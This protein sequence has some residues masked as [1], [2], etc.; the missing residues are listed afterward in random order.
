MKEKKVHILQED[1]EKKSLALIKQ[2]GRSIES[3][4]VKE[5]DVLLEWHQVKCPT[6]WKKENKLG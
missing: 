2:E 3:Y 4:S 1:I 5:L 6:G